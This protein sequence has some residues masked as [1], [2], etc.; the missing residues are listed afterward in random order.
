MTVRHLGRD[1][2]LYIASEVLGPSFLVR[3]FGLLESAVARPRTTAF[4]QDAYQTVHHKAAA[5]LHSLAANHPLV[6]GNKRLAWAACAVFLRLNGQP[7]RATQDQV[8]DFVASVAAGVLA[9]VEKI[10]ERLAGWT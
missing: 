8:V 3:D 1:D 10:A 5:L 6:D 4:G 2:L 9:D 7:P